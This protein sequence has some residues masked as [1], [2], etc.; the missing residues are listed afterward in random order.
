M[1]GTGHAGH[2]PAI[3]KAVQLSQRELEVLRAIAEFGTVPAAARV[4]FISRNTVES[5]LA[6]VRDKVGLDH[7][8]QLVAWAIREA[9]LDVREIAPHSID[10]IDGA[11]E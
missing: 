5:H 7:L 1:A 2:R 9:L 10:V 3:E 4:L 6:H 11:G 8:P